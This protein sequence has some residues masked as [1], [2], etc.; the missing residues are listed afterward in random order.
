MAIANTNEVGVRVSLE[1]A[2]AETPSSPTMEEMQ[3]TGGSPAPS[4]ETVVSDIL[5]IDRQRADLAEVSAGASGS[6]NYE[7]V[8]SPAMDLFIRAM[9][10]SDWVTVDVT[11]TTIQ[12]QI[13][14]PSAG[15]M[16]LTRG[17]GDFTADGMLV[18]HRLRLQ[19]MDTAA[20]DGIYVVETVGTTTCV[21]RQKASGNVDETT[22]S[23]AEIHVKSIRNG[24]TATSLLMEQ[25]FGG[26][27]PRFRQYVGMRVGSYQQTITAQQKISG[28]IT[29][30]GKQL[31]TPS[32][33]TVAGLS[34][35]APAAD[36]VTASANVAT[37]VQAGTDM[38]IPV[39]G[40]DWTYNNNLN[41]VPVVGSKYPQEVGAG[42]IDLSGTLDMYYD[43]D[44]TAMNAMLNHTD[45]DLEIPITDGSGNFT[46]I[47]MFRLKYS[48]GPTNIPGG[49]ERVTTPFGFQGVKH[50]NGSTIQI[51]RLAI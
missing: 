23:G 19:G 11:G 24:S 7:L 42:F 50:S 47:T 35:T 17:T 38:T 16:T 15:S 40:V 27:G 48:E 32:G 13:D 5:T 36:I 9:M 30:E 14:T 20:N 3:Y 10:F 28:S 6:I 41:Q 8:F 21:V 39:R 46:G 25:E 45:V 12:S 22:A 31:L 26:V 51:D 29:M 1:T 34:N 18:G 4:K 37:L 2:W 44:E 49:N 33:S 43:G